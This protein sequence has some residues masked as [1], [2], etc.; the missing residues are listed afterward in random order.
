MCKSGYAQVFAFLRWHVL[1]LERI[2]V[3]PQFAQA[4]REAFRSFP[5]L[6]RSFLGLLR[7]FGPGRD[8]RAVCVAPAQPGR[9][10]PF[11]G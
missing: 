1:T 8:Q 3:N 2:R 6:L 7:P 10:A 4:R 9:Y 11:S 5:L